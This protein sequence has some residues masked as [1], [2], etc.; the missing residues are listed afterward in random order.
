[1]RGILERMETLGIRRSELEEEFIRGSGS[2]GQKIN[3]TSSTV[4][5]RHLPTG[6]E[7]RC[8]DG[9]SRAANRYQ[10]RVL[11]CD[12]LEEKITAAFQQARA[13][14]SKKRRQNLKRSRGSKARMLAEKRQRSEVKSM[15]TRPKREEE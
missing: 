4:V 3:K 14:V 10:A 6:I 11:L 9:R 8:Q 1:M 15:R 7:I 2:G 13:A 5:L 12:K